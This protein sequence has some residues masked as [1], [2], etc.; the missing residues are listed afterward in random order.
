MPLV[1]SDEVV[2]TKDFDKLKEFMVMYHR[3]TE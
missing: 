3:T 2:E 1:V